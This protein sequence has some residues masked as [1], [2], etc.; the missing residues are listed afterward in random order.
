M[1]VLVPNFPL[2]GTNLSFLEARLSARQEPAHTALPRLREGRHL[3]LAGDAAPRTNADVEAKANARAKILGYDLPQDCDPGADRVA[4]SPQRRHSPPR[5]EAR[6]HCN[7]YGRPS[8]HGIIERAALIFLFQI[9]IFDAGIARVFRSADGSI[10]RP[11]DKIRFKGTRVYA[12]LASHRRMEY[13]PK[14]DLES[15][16]YV[17]ASF[18]TGTLP[19]RPL[20]SISSTFILC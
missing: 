3:R 16:L 1:N 4:G 2:A 5:L 7:R 6:Q 17:M 12:P 20:V 19:W 18:S 9:I 15:F 14:D 13:A 10:H 8:E 11:R